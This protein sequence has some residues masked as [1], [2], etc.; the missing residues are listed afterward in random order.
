MGWFLV[1]L[2]LLLHSFAAVKNEAIKCVDYVC[3]RINTSQHTAERE[4][5]KLVADNY[6]LQYM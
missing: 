5:D 2:V 1:V 4:A 6:I 3:R